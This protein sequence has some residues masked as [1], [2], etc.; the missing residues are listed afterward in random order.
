MGR[1]STH[2][3]TVPLPLPVGNTLYAPGIV[4]STATDVALG[5]GSST[6][7]VVSRSSTFTANVT[8]ALV[9]STGATA[10]SLS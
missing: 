10:G 7:E 2:A 3:D 4:R 6:I 8:I 1:S 9:G 5:S